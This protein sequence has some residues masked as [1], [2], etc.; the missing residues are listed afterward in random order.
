[1][2]SRGKEGPRGCWETEF[3]KHLHSVDEEVMTALITHHFKT[4]STKNRLHL[5]TILEH[6]TK[7]T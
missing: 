3:N 4:H 1:M 7:Q 5:H 2:E 6:K